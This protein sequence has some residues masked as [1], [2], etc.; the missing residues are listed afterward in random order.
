MLRDII[1]Y[2]QLRLKTITASDRG[3][4]QIVDKVNINVLSFNILFQLFEKRKKQNIPKKFNTVSLHFFI[5]VMYFMLSW[6]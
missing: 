6:S 5:F 1:T 4:L 2:T 3:V